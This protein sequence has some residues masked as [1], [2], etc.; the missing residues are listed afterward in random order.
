M[1]KLQT[2]INENGLK[3]SWFAGKIGISPTQLS[4][5]LNN[6]RKPSLQL[7]VKIDRETKGKVSVYDWELIHPKN[8]GCATSHAKKKENDDG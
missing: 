4:Y 8:H 2:Y 7:A 6:H 3:H 1:K 5:L